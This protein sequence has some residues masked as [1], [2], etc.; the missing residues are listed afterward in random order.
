MKN[1][2]LFFGLSLFIVAGINA[3]RYNDGDALFMAS[4]H[5]TICEGT[6]LDGSQMVRAFGKGKTARDAKKQLE[7]NAMRDVLFHGIREGVEGC[8]VAPLINDPSARDKHKKYFNRFFSDG[9]QYK[10]YVKLNDSPKH[11][12]KR[13]KGGDGDKEKL[14]T[15][16]VTI[17]MYKMEKELK[18]EGIIPKDISKRKQK[19]KPKKTDF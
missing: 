3:Q 9:G 18:R 13:Y 8:E 6:E 17:N 16:I 10:R 19:K 5:P 2:I 11:S 12:T 14:W 15:K 4:N 1:Q 7:K